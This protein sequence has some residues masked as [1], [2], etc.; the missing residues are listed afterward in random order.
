MVVGVGE[1]IKLEYQIKPKG[2]FFINEN[3]PKNYPKVS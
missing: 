1:G 2:N 3:Y